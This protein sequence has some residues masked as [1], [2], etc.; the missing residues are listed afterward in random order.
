M[1]L[2]RGIEPLPP[3][4]KGGVL[5]RS[6]MGAYNIPVL[7]ATVGKT[8]PDYESISRFSTNAVKQ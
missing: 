7:L 8:L 6:T 5:Y 4:W 3:P 1:A 2:P